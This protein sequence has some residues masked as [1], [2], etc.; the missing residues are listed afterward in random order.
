MD[1]LE[2]HVSPDG[3]LKFIVCRDDGDVCL[4]FDGY[5]WHTHP[6]LLVSDGVSPEVATR[7]FVDELLAGRIVIVVSR[8]EGV[9]RDVWITD[10][11]ESQL[12]YKMP[13]E[14]LEFRYW[15][16]RQATS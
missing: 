15:D 11:T 14:T 13:N 10:D 16:G 3:L 4:G 6:E 1:I 12:K 5:P 9:V 8:A 7:Q 2:Q